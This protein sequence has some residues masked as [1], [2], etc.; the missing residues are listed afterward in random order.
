LRG[1]EKKLREEFKGRRGREKTENT[2]HAE[3]HAE[4]NQSTSAIHGLAVGQVRQMPK[5]KSARLREPK[6]VH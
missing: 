1:E 4:K 3:A 5:I 2:Q 6:S